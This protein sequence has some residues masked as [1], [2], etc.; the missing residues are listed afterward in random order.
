MVP[1]IEVEAQVKVISVE[2]V[3]AIDDW[4]C[5]CATASRAF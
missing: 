2:V 1:L 3:S 5:A 4:T